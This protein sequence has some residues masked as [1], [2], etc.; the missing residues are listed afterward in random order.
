M[1]DAATSSTLRRAGRDVGFVIAAFVKILNPGAIFVATGIPLA[2]DI[3][4]SAIR[5]RVYRRTVRLQPSD[6]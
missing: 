5:E 3:M 2:D 1:E 4:L 6:P